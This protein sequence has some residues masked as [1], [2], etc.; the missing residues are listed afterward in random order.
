MRALEIRRT[1]PIRGAFLVNYPY[2]APLLLPKR[3]ITITASFL[4]RRPTNILVF[5][6]SLP[7]IVLGITCWIAGFLREAYTKKI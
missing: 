3:V 7:F 4:K 5:L 1:V 6:L 2:L